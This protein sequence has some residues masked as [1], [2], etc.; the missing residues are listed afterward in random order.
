MSSRKL[1]PV[2]RRLREKKG[3]TM[4]QL[5]DRAGVTDA[6]I[7]MLETGKRKNPSLATLRRIAKA[8]KVKVGDLLK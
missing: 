6:Y 1:G 3:L 4:Q 7:A 8:L 2:L 5:A